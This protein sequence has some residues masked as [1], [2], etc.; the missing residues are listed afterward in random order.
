MVRRRTWLLLVSL[1]MA[2]PSLA[3]KRIISVAPNLTEILFA[4][5]AGSSVV[6]VSDYCQYPE[7]AREKP[8]IGGPFN[9]NY[10]LMISLQADW[11]LMPRS[12]AGPAEKCRSLG[13]PVLAL[14]N[15]TVG[16]VLDAIHRLGEVTGKIAEASR[17]AAGIR[18]RLDRIA[19]ATRDLPRPRVLV[20]VLRTPRGLQDLTAA[21]SQTFLNELLEMAGGRNVLGKTLSR[22]PRVSKEEI[23]ALD[24][25]VVFDLTFTGEGED[26][27][28]V[29]AALP[30]LAAVRSGRIIPMPDPSVTIPGPRMVQTLERFLEVLHPNV[31]VPPAVTEKKSR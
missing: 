4:I 28:A 11:V 21:S 25:E 9:L 26:T 19:E 27:R 14:P 16:E 23:V 5:E 24:P 30:T 6:A 29:W 13:I 17:L 12:L 10:E 15:E 31:D 3:A 2:T 7:Q 22:Y 20:V 1:L 8:R 18:G